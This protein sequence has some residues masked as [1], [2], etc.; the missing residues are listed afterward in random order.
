MSG[1]EVLLQAANRQSNDANSN[2]T[3][4][5][6]AFSN[7]TSQ[8]ASLYTNYVSSPS[9]SNLPPKKRIKLST[10]NSTTCSDISTTASSSTTSTLK[11]TKSWNNTTYVQ[12]RNS[13]S[14]SLFDSEKGR[15]DDSMSVSTIGM[16]SVSSSQR[17]GISSSSARLLPRTSSSLYSSTSK[18]NEVWKN[19]SSNNN[20][21]PTLIS[22]DNN[23][24]ND[25][26]L[27]RE[28]LSR[29]GKRDEG[30]LHQLYNMNLVIPTSKKQ[31][32]KM[33]PMK[34]QRCKLP[35]YKEDKEL[36]SSSSCTDINGIEM[37]MGY[38]SS[39]L[40][41]SATSSAT[42][43][44]TNHP[45]ERRGKKKRPRTEA[46]VEVPQDV[47][48]TSTLTEEIPQDVKS[49]ATSTE[50]DPQESAITTVKVPQVRSRAPKAKQQ[51]E[52]GSAIVVNVTTPTH[53]LNNN[54]LMNEN[55][56]YLIA[57][58]QLYQAYLQA[59]NKQD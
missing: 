39:S 57:K 30:G 7:N 56:K 15:F 4:E 46:V 31:R 41:T 8:A 55:A 43:S 33:L 12:F 24:I 34:K 23:T 14:L 37:G 32:Q 28:G 38:F 13:N 22:N 44:L 25:K 50:E 21:S 27:R 58:S 48:P 40:S 11:K 1:F 29:V 2:N 47:L 6:Q 51:Q 36:A 49:A 18:K 53:K 5:L 10:T 52:E 54:G 45:Q 20:D 26:M 42:L 35:H 59:L 17:S 16:R 3:I 19:F 9:F